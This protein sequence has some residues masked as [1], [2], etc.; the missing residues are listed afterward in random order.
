MDE[1][2]LEEIARQA[3]M[4]LDHVRLIQLDDEPYSEK[5]LVKQHK[6]RSNNS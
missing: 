1:E 6:W 3:G 4:T 5:Q 2:R